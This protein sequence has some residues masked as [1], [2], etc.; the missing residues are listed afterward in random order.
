MNEIQP[1]PENVTSLLRMAV[2]ILG[3]KNESILRG[4][5][6]VA[7]AAGCTAGVK[8]VGQLIDRKIAP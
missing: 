8:E 4:L 1:L 6:E 7:F 5:A 2:S 3:A